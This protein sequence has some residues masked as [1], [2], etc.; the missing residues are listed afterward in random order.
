MDNQPANPLQ[1]SILRGAVRDSKN[2]KI[3]LPNISI[4][5][6]SSLDKK[7][8]PE[9][10]MAL[11]IDKEPLSLKLFK[12]VLTVGR[13]AFGKVWKSTHLASGAT[14]AIKEMSKRKILKKKCPNTIL[15]EKKILSLLKNK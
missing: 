1:R 13:G 14:Y 9:E 10:E 8:K 15:N 5:N 3:E 6:S 4:R 7:I 12:P 11:K 2:T